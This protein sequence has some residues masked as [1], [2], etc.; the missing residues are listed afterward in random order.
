M[1]LLN[2]TIVVIVR[3]VIAFF[4]LHI[5]TR[6]LGKQQV[7]QLTFFEYALGIT[8]GSIAASLTTELDSRAWI[9]FIG[10]IVW[11][12]SALLLQLI[13]IRWRYMSKSV[14]G[15]PVVIVMNGKI[16][17]EAMKKAR[18]RA[19]DLMGQL[20]CKNVF[21]L[22]EVE[23]AI[24]ETNGEI[25]VLKKSQFQPVTAQQM[26]IPVT[27]TSMG[28]ELIHDGE[29]VKQNLKNLKLN[30]EWLHTQLEARG[31]R[32][33]SE[34]FLATITTNGSFYVDTY[35]DKLKRIIDISD[36]IGPN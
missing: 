16:M 13:T 5:F 3:G 20:R 26:N 14:D 25:S 22:N 19:V 32:D 7:S 12:M 31:I 6:I 1:N 21:D 30:E 24:L 10:L 29:I 15:E 11:A 8:I 34:V 18:Y 27:P 2:E 9:H 17:E 23:F 28:I 4:S 33:V 35:Q 36:Y